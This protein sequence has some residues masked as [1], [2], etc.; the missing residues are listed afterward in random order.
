ME[1]DKKLSSDIPNYGQPISP[2]TRFPVK[3]SLRRRVSPKTIIQPIPVIAVDTSVDSSPLTY[4]DTISSALTAP[5]I[6]SPLLATSAVAEPLM[7]SPFLA[8]SAVSES[9][10]H[11]PGLPLALSPLLPSPAGAHSP[12]LPSPAGAHS[13]LLLSPAGIE[14]LMRPPLHFTSASTLPLMH[15]SIQPRRFVERK[16]LSIPESLCMEDCLP[17]NP[18]MQ[19]HKGY[20]EAD[21]NTRGLFL[22]KW[23]N[24][25]QQF[26]CME[27]FVG[28]VNDQHAR[29]ERPDLE[30]RCKW[31]GCQRKGKGFNA[32]YKILIHIRTHT[33][34]KP[35]KCYRCGKS[36]AR[37]ENLKIHSRT[38]TGEKPYSCPFEGCDKAYSNS[39]DRFKHVRTHKEGRPYAC[40]IP[41][42]NKRYTDP[43]SLRK[44]VKTQMHHYTEQSSELSPNLPL[45]SY[46][47]KDND[48][49]SPSSHSCFDFS[50]KI[51]VSVTKAG[52]KPSAAIFN[53]L[54]Q[55]S[56]PLI[57]LLRPVPDRRL[58]SAFVP[59]TT[60][61]LS[62]NAY[63]RM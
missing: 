29:I 44:H 28:H 31:A 8:T 17:S 59:V 21:H 55:S 18:N 46:V 19:T 48:V 56:L 49:K 36:F 24:C 25:E 11:S 35:H 63:M 38:H 26:S 39:S 4:I 3:R 47:S 34:E 41:G 53:S 51:S 50:G 6:V 7:H 33:K 54:E 61:A 37:P 2:T 23:I 20:G 40:K 13:P 12:L 27:E 32:R 15:P 10:I 14:Q 42:C 22:C 62:P 43:S 9:F 57:D 58:S 52:C 1:T 45:H 16:S 60:D 30:Y 5:V